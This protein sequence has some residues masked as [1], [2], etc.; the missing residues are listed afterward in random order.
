MIFK[1]YVL[2]FNKKKPNSYKP[3]PDLVSCFYN[4][5]MNIHHSFNRNFLEK[6]LERFI[7]LY[8]YTFDV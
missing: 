6:K 5:K 2:M 3:C 7:A 8:R 1:I 4:I